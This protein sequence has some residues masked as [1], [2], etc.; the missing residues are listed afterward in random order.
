[1]IYWLSIPIPVPT[2]GMVAWWLMIGC[3]FLVGRSMW[4]IA[5]SCDWN[6]GNVAEPELL[7]AL[8]TLVFWPLFGMQMIKNTI[9]AGLEGF[10]L[11]VCERYV[12]L[13]EDGRR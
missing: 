8:L 2:L 7:G 4:M 6:S 3:V 1:M 10:D 12:D 11:Y 13:F 9:D 5:K